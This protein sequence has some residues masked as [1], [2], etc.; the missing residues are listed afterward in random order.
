MFEKKQPSIRAAPK[1]GLEFSVALRAEEQ[2]RSSKKM[3]VAAHRLNILAAIFF[4]I[5]TLMTIFGVNLKHGLEERYWPWP[6]LVCAG[7]GLAGG[8]VLTSMLSR[9]SEDSAV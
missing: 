4:P 1:N 3:A 6:F 2:A 5:A 9:I 8:I 7:L